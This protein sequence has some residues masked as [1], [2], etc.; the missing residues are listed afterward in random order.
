MNRQQDKHR[1]QRDAAKATVAPVAATILE[2]TQIAKYHTKGGHGFAA[3]DANNVVDRLRGKNAQIVGKTSERNGADRLVDGVRIQS[4]YYK[5]ASDTVGSAF[6]RN[7]NYRYA[8]QVLEV[9]KDQYDLCVAHM[10]RCIREGRVPGHADPA[11]AEKLV[12]KGTV[13]YRQ[14][15]NI[16]RAGNVDSVKFDVK[17]GA[18]I[19]VGTVGL[20]FALNYAQ[21]YRQG[22]AHHDALDVAL[23]QALAA[24]SSAWVAHLVSAQLL[25]TKAAAVCAV[26]ARGA[27]RAAAGSPLGRKAVD[28]IAAASLG[29]VVHGAAA[30]N[31]VGKLLRSN[32]VTGSV[33]VAVSCA[34]DFYRAAFD[35]S[36]SWGQFTKNTAVQAAS[37]AVG[38][39]MG[40]AAVGAS[41]GS[42]MPGIGTAIGAFIGGAI[43]ALGIGAAS[44]AAAKTIA[45]G[46]V[47]DDAKALLRILEEELQTLAQEYML[48][49]G[50]F[51][52][53]VEAVRC[54]IDGKWLRGMYRQ[55]QGKKRRGRKFVRGR[56]EANFQSIVGRR[57]VVPWPGQ[58]APLVRFLRSLARPARNLGRL[59][60][61]KV[62]VARQGCRNLA[63]RANRLLAA[64][65]CDRWWQRAADNA[66]QYWWRLIAKRRRARGWL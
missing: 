28:G 44:G 45:D 29:K 26:T 43:G 36:I 41:V 15:R 30:V 4:K 53:I 42:A 61:N 49:L 12:A 56:F 20:S 52:K 1:E 60:K 35:Q 24:G 32:A 19:A 65:P 48:S 7:G 57:P 25:R 11:D 37:V 66:R 55:T 34:P 46:L 63:A 6:D 64:A 23:K 38:G 58:Q 18:A 54:E 62:G 59:A 9:P 8:G 39:W 33:L 22:L 10:R 3:E 13:T 40:G 31:H 51:E 21:A 5:T 14:A 16:A 27:V 2:Q 47:E 50:E 17:T